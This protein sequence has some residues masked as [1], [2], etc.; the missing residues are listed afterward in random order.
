MKNQKRNQKSTFR[1]ILEWLHLWLGLTS[2]I[3]VFIVCL[4]AALWV[5]RDEMDYFANPEERITKEEKDF[6]K[7]SKILANAKDYLSNSR[8]GSPIE[9]SSISYR[10]KTQTGY[11]GFRTQDST[12]LTAYFN[13]YNGKVLFVKNNEEARLSKFLLFVRAGHRWIWLPRKIG[14]PVVGTSCI[15]FLITIITGLIWW[16]PKKWN[17]ST[18]DKSFKIK[19]KAKWKRLNIDLHN[20]LGFYAFAFSFILITT[21]I[22]YSFKWF[23]N[24]SKWTLTGKTKEE[25]YESKYVLPLNHFNNRDTVDVFYNEAN[26]LTQ[27]N[28]ELIYLRLPTKENDSYAANFLSKSGKNHSQLYYVWEG[29]NHSIVAKNKPFQDKKWGERMYNYNFEL[30]VGT[31]FGLPSKILACLTSLIGAS[32]PV[33]G[34]IIWLNR[35]RKKNKKIV[36]K[37][38]TKI[39]CI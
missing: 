1:K 11:I 26:K 3:V 14:S 38:S 15:L 10:S 7:P 23:N 6:V 28:N 5:F 29:V 37:E 18:R 22:A 20:V 8:Y 9:I 27:R 19:F 2:G 12:Y 17:Q 35:K 32:L 4:M 31:I 21:G 30:H 25:K 16:Y 34:F 24:F 36:N 13:P 39:A 33:T